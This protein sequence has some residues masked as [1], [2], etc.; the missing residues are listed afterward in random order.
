MPVLFLIGGDGRIVR[1]V[2][3]TNGC[4][5]PLQQVLAALQ[6]VPWIMVHPSAQP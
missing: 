6:F 5:L 3:P 2:I 4:G 1:P